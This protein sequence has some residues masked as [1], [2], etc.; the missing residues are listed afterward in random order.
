[1]T[2]SYENINEICENAKSAN[3]H[4]MLSDILNLRGKTKKVFF[5][6]A[7][8]EFPDIYKKIKQEYKTGKTSDLYKK[9]LYKML[10]E[11]RE[12]H[13]ISSGY[14]KVLKEKLQKLPIQTQ[15]ELF[16]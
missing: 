15:C 1:M 11:L 2:D 10:N 14:S 3:V 6:F 7:E 12:K 9:Q 16:Q 4:Y 5:N 13:K 8:K